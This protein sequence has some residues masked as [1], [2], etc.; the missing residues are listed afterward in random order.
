[1]N[2]MRRPARSFLFLSAK[3]LLA[4]D[5]EKPG[6]TIDQAGCGLSNNRI[7]KWGRPD[8]ADTTGRVPAIACLFCAVLLPSSRLPMPAYPPSRYDERR[9][10][11]GDFPVHRRQA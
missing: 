4:N 9:S 11:R 2:T 10:S 5:A 6:A 1:M 3:D 8:D 7:T